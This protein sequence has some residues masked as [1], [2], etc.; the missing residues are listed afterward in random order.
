MLFAGSMI[1]LTVRVLKFARPRWLGFICSIGLE[2][3]HRFRPQA[4]QLPAGR[5]FFAQSGLLTDSIS[6]QVRNTTV[7]VWTVGEGFGIGT[8][9]RQ[10]CCAANN[11][12]DHN[13][14]SVKASLVHRAHRLLSESTR[15]LCALRSRPPKSLLPVLKKISDGRGR[16]LLQ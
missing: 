3:R 12:R 8:E 15:I 1:S 10:T 2:D 13:L 16:S 6:G 7:Q 4:L 9:F 11:L 5:P 14:D